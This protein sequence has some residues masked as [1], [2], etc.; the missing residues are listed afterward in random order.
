MSRPLALALAAL[1]ALGL[2]GCASFSADGG[3]G[4]VE[5][6]ARQH[7]DKSVQWPRSES[8]RARSAER[9][10]EMLAAPLSM[11]AAVQLA[12]LNNPGLQAEF[13][14]L[15]IAEADL[16]QAGR[17]P[18]PGFSFGRFTR[19]DEV[20]LERSVHFDLA[21]LLAWP[22]VQRIEQRRFAQA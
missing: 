6:A 16:V 2:A 12:L 1:A 20:E 10:R 5:Q 4:P 17:L 7:L 9:V 19:G 15:G 14:T 11:D 13:E 3:F 8:E 21:R 18:N 22:L